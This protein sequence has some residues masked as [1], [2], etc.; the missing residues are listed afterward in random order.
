MKFGWWSILLPLAGHCVDVWT[1]RRHALRL[2]SFTP[3]AASA[4]T[5]DV[6]DPSKTDEVRGVVLKN[7]LRYVDKSVGWG[8][9]PRWG[10]VLRISY[11]QWVRRSD[12]SLVKI[13]EQKSY[14]VRHG[15]GRTVRG[16]DEGLHTMRIGGRRRIEVPPKLGY[17]IVGLGPIPEGPGQTRR[18]N[19]ALDKMGDNGAVVFDVQLLESWVDA[20]D[21]GLYN[22]SSFSEKEMAFIIMRIQQSVGGAS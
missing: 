14:L 5:V 11:V 9:E 2:V 17:T 6:V 10:D 16:L 7:G 21:I 3:V 19:N 4:T 18:F 13:D 12:L 20:A 15:N 1:T 22:D 8:N